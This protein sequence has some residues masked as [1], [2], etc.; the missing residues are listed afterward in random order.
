MAEWFQVLLIAVITVLLIEARFSFGTRLALMER[1]LAW[2]IASLRKWGLVAPGHDVDFRVASAPEQ[3]QR[4]AGPVP[5]R[6]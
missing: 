1:D 5:P 2:L 4:P 6:R 3:D